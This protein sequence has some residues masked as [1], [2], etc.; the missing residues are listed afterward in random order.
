MSALPQKADRLLDMIDNVFGK[1]LKLAGHHLETSSQTSF[2]F[3]R[4]RRRIVGRFANRIGARLS[5]AACALDPEFSC[6]WPERRCWPVAGA[7][8]VGA[9]RST[10]RNHC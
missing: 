2:P 10:I 6:R 7:M 3:G 1:V 4:R 5:D 9:A 8:V